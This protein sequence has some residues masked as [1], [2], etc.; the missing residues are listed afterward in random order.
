[1]GAIF[2]SWIV[3]AL[4]AVCF[5][6]QPPARLPQAGL[7]LLML[8]FLLHPRCFAGGR[9]AFSWSSAPSLVKGV[10]VIGMVVGSISAIDSL[11]HVMAGR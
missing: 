11:L 10:W 3:G 4:Y 9:G 7:P 5:S 1:M 2:L 8:G 6:D